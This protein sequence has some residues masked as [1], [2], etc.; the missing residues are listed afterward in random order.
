MKYGVI[1]KISEELLSKFICRRFLS[2]FNY[3]ASLMKPIIMAN[4]GNGLG[5]D[6]TVV[7]DIQYDITC[8]MYLFRLRDDYKHN[9]FFE[10]IEGRQYP[11]VS[12][13]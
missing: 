2:N 7:C 5:L 9:G 8:D 4:L 3:V 6:E 11:V 13:I 1:V 12:L 10:A